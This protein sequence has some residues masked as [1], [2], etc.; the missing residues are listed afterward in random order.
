MKTACLTCLYSSKIGTGKC[1]IPLNANNK[2]EGKQDTADGKGGDDAAPETV[3]RTGAG[4]GCTD[5]N[6]WTVLQEQNGYE[7]LTVTHSE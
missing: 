2:A 3:C 6:A 4:D 7:R 1:G 5:I